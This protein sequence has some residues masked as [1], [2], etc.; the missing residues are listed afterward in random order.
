MSNF[1][2]IFNTSVNI[3]SIVICI[4][5][6][7]YVLAGARTDLRLDRFFLLASGCQ[8]LFGIATIAR[9][10]LNGHPGIE[11][12]T[13]LQIAC[14]VEYFSPTILLVLESNYLLVSTGL[15]HTIFWR[16][17]IGMLITD[18]VLLTVSQF[19]GFIYI[20]DAE[21]I[22][23]RSSGYLW[24]YFPV[25]VLMLMNVIVLIRKR[26]KLQKR[27][28]LAF[29]VYLF[30]PFVS[31]VLQI[32][33]PGISFG[34][35]AS[36]MGI[37]FLY[38]TIVSVR[39]TQYYRQVQEIAKLETDILLAQIHPHFLFNSLS[40]IKSLCST[41]PE[42]A[43]NAI[44][45]F[46]GYL[47]HNIESITTEHLTPFSEELEH[48]RCYL[49]LQQLRF[50]DV[51]QV[52]Y[53]LPYT[54]FRLPTLTLQPL[55]ENAVTHGIRKSETGSGCITIRTRRYPDHFEIIVADNGVGFSP[56][57]LP[58]KDERRHIGLENV[59]KRLENANGEL[60][61]HSVPGEGTTAT[62]ILPEER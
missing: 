34:V 25:A 62:I 22:Y 8:I 42:T 47:R 1:A 11:N 56:N 19:T 59:R 53:E 30:L 48:T 61:I 54:D 28:E 26:E 2:F 9:Y 51:L 20:I 45:Y 12:R 14:Y 21:N 29:W 24:C 36:S 4:Q 10:L 15:K 37:L 5:G 43:R 33:I 55:V 52:V 13:L 41:D 18:I 6:I 49:K 46:S 32:L 38:R 58:A 44:D 50:G 27:E 7:A 16:I 3:C 40:V 60:Q 57:S 39:T 17:P 23:R 35:L 31:I